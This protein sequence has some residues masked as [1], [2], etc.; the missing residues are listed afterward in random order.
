MN[1]SNIVDFT[2]DCGQNTVRGAY[3]SA[4][5]LPAF[6]NG[7]A[8]GQSASVNGRLPQFCVVANAGGTVFGVTLQRVAGLYPYQIQVDA[9]GPRGIGSGYMYLA[10][11][12]LS[13]DTYYLRI[14]SSDRK[15]HTVGYR[16]GSPNLQAIYWSNYDFTVPDD[17]AAD[18]DRPKPEYQ[19]ISPVE[20]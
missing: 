17:A 12:D 11:R 18:A 20:A 15:Q 9:Q 19:V 3:F 5:C 16:S 13:G 4:S 7:L 8:P 1:D 6:P 10:F 14:F 2:G